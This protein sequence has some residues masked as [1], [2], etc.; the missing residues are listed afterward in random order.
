[1]MQPDDIQA[2]LL[3]SSELK[4]LL[5]GTLPQVIWDAGELLASALADGGK[6]I[7]LGNGGSAAD[8]QHLAAEWVGRFVKE[9]RPLSAVALTTDSSA[10]TC[11]SN[12]YGFDH[13]FARQIE[14]IGRSGDACVAISTSGRSP[15]VIRAVEAA[16]RLGIATI[17]LL[18]NDGGDVAGLVRIPIVVP[19]SVTARIQ[20]CHITIG[21]LLCE[22]VDSVLFA[23]ADGSPAGGRWPSATTAAKILDWETLLARRA[24]WRK[25]GKTVAW[26]N[27][28]FELLDAGHVQNLQAARNCGDLLVVGVNSDASVRAL[29]GA[30]RPVTP[31]AERLEII[32]ALEC[33]DFV[34]VLDDPNP[35]EALSRLRPEVHCKG[36]GHAGPDGKAMPEL[37]TVRAYGGRVELIPAKPAVSTTSIGARVRETG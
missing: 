23:G 35:T 24:W 15:N 5:A 32:A 9:R 27:G 29:K 25:V 17:G 14:A 10:L 30:D 11:I 33:V 37:E 7:L 19:S 16:N 8:A 2:R 36:A 26:T 21:H 4:R 28:C 3:E 22:M 6:V 18:G 34:V 31:C 20:E 12:D 1:M 13:V